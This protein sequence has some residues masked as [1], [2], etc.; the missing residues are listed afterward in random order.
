MS[1][2]TVEIW[3]AAISTL[4]LIGL[5][6]GYTSKRFKAIV[7]TEF[8]AFELR[9]SESLDDRFSAINECHLRHDEI[10]RRLAALEQRPPVTSRTSHG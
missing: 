6:V 9:F 5:V 2:I 1:P 4:T 3:G 10:N 7:K 8:L